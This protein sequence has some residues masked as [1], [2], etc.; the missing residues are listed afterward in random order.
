MNIPVWSA[1]EA[2]DNAMGS[3]DSNTTIP[4]LDFSLWSSP[5]SSTTTKQRLATDLVAAFQHSGFVYLTNHGLAQPSLSTAFATSKRLF[6]LTHEKKMLAPHPPGPEVHRGY[7]WPGLEKVSQ[8]L[9]TGD[10]KD[11]DR[12]VA[13]RLREVSDCKESFEIGSEANAAQ[14]NVWVPEATLPGFREWGTVFYWECYGV[15]MEILK[16]VAVGLGVE[17]DEF[18]KYHSGLNCQLRL[19][20]Y[21]PLLAKDVEQGRVARMPA[22]SDWSTITMLFQDDC[23]GLEVEDPSAPGTFVAAT[24]VAGAC[25][26]NVGDLLMRWSNGTFSGAGM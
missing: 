14:P 19:L 5:Q 21:P 12:K 25:V 1:A 10:D 16:A 6:D 8:H 18:V 3:I 24:P 26:V 9:G 20:H 22:H 4:I 13:E 17:E 15:A 7:S 2:T 23:G 11:G